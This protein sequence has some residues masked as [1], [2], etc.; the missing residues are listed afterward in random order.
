MAAPKKNIRETI[1]GQGRLLEQVELLVPGFSGY[2]EKEVRREAD[3]I[4]RE[5]LAGELKGVDEAIDSAYEDIT[6]SKITE[7]YDA[8]NAATA[9]MD[10]II[11]KVETADYGYAGFFSAVKI[12]EDAL[13][14]MYEFDKKMFADVEAISDGAEKLSVAIEKDDRAKV[15]ALAKEL[16]KAI[17]DFDKKFDQR[18]AVLLNLE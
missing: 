14:S 17:M 10:K 16:K 12:R 1:K 18:K 5:A 3:K 15:P 9:L 2:K 6:G 11:G 7:A 8:M 13:D 4:L